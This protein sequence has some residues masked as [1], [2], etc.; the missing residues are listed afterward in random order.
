M[1][2]YNLSAQSIK[3]SA[4]NVTF[5]VAN[6]KFRTVEGS[7]SG[8]TG[9]LTFDE[10]NLEVC[11]FDVCVDATTLNT[12]NSKRDSH[13]Q[14][15]EFFDTDKHPEI[16]FVSEMVKSSHNGY[17][18][19]GQLTM[20]GVTQSVMIPFTFDGTTFAGDLTLSRAD[21][22][23]GADTNNFLIGDTIEIR[24]VCVVE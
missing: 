1:T 19:V 22:S 5:E 2:T 17:A 24:I 6:M 12:D 15:P 7:V 16:C 10:S 8:M 9:N 21:Y 14:Q 20:K 18:V 11:E 4:S 3:S 13:L 23:I